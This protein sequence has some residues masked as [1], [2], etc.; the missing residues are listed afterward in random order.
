VNCDSTINSE[1]PN[2]ELLDRL[3]DIPEIELSGF[4][5]RE[6]L[7]GS[8]VTMLRGTN[9]FG[10]WRAVGNELVWMHA[11]LAQPTHAV[12]TVDEA[13]HYSLLLILRNLETGQASK[14]VPQKLAG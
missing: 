9:Y 4:S 2:N 11:N 3:K 7:S 5:V 14:P 6:G 10:S 12:E 13:V 8:G 1:A